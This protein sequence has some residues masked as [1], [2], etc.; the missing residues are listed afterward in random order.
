MVSSGFSKCRLAVCLAAVVL[1]APVLW[2]CAGG[3]SARGAQVDS[4]NTRQ[5]TSLRAYD[6]VLAMRQAGF[7][8][9]QIVALG[10][11]VRNAVAQGGGAQVRIDGRTE[12]LLAVEGHHLHVT[13]R[14]G[15][16]RSYDLLASPE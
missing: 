2:G 13:S 11:D 6:I 4:M 8:D 12:A 15:Q 5:P 1:M 3:P 10:T 16:T 14:R 7:T 9:E